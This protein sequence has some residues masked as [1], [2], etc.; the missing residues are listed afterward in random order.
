M[1]APSDSS[2]ARNRVDRFERLHHGLR[3][4]AGVAGGRFQYYMQS[5]G[6]GNTETGH[7]RAL[8]TRIEDATFLSI[9][10]LGSDRDDWTFLEYALSDNDH[11][12]L[13]LVDPDRFED[14]LEDVPSIRQRVAEQ[15]QDPEL[16]VGSLS[17][18]R[19]GTKAER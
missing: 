16:F 12:R 3:T 15:L 7:S 6:G 1:D 17:C 19:Q 14:V 4:P 10:D 9:R 2:A 13:R 5:S 18:S 11:L 8:A